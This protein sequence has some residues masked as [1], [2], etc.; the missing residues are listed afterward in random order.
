MA[1]IAGDAR[2]HAGDQHADENAQRRQRTLVGD[3]GDARHHQRE[4]DREPAFLQRHGERQRQCGDRAGREDRG[5]RGAARPRLA[6]AQRFGG[7][8]EQRGE[9]QRD[10]GERHRLLELV[11]A[12][13]ERDQDRERHEHRAAPPTASARCGCRRAA[14]RQE[15]GGA[16][17][18]GEG[19]AEREMRSVEH[20]LR[21]GDR[22]GRR[23]P[24]A[25]RAA[26][27]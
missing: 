24:T 17:Q 21:L 16:E 4:R 11:D 7:E 18:R 2:Q 8:R 13:V 26:R 9:Q 3:P 25:A 5:R 1:R 15:A 27:S 12:V 23:R 6:A 14:L 20:V 22:A 10:A 19:G